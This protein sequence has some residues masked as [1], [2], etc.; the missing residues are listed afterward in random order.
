MNDHRDRDLTRAERQVL[1]ELLERASDTFSNHGC[2][3]FELAKFMPDP[4]ERRELMREYHEYNHSPEDYDPN[5]DFN[6]EMDFALMSFFA[7]KLL[8]VEG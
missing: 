7:W 2:N 1:A 8:G 5:D 4:E 3:D 6:V